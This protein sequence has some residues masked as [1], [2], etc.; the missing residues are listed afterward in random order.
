MHIEYNFVNQC[1]DIEGFEKQLNFSTR[2]NRPEQMKRELTQ[3]LKN[4]F[5]QGNNGI[6]K[7]RYITFGIH[8]ENVKQAKPRLT[9]LQNDII[10]NFK[11]IGVEAE[12]LDGKERLRLMHSIY[13]INESEPFRFEWK[14]II[15]TGATV[16]DFIAPTAFA[17][18]SSRTFQMGGMYCAVS[19]IK[20]YSD[21]WKMSMRSREGY[22]YRKRSMHFQSR[23]NFP[24]SCREVRMTHLPNRRLPSHRTKARQSPR[25]RFQGLQNQLLL[26]QLKLNPHLNTLRT[27][28]IVSPPTTSILQ[29]GIWEKV[30]TRKNS[31]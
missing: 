3:I 17:F 4:Q 28:Q 11:Q 16:Y 10:S 30:V 21:S 25:L 12:V 29:T 6:T 2:R 5:E 20:G 26:T 15:P 19:Y 24:T 18:R 8:A 27:I 22:R 1:T 7:T 9:H 13:H 23:N 14:Y 31:G